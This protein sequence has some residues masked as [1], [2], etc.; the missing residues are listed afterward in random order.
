ME[1]R[2]V[3]GPGDTSPRDEFN[4][5]DLRSINIITGV[6]IVGTELTVDQL[7]VKVSYPY[8]EGSVEIIDLIAPS[9]YDA[10]LSSDGYY[11]A[12]SRVLINPKSLTY[13]TMVRYY[14]NGKL[15]AKMYVKSVDRISKDI[16]KI[17]TMSAIGLME[18][19]KHYGNLYRG[20]KFI[21]VLTEIIGGAVEFTVADDVKNLHIYGWLPYD[22]KRRNLHQ[23]LFPSGVM[24]DKD[25]N[26]DLYFRFISNAESKQVPK[27]RI[28]YGGKVD[29]PAFASAVDVTEHSFFAL[30]TDQVVTVYDNTDGSETAD[31]TF[32]AFRD[33]PLHD[34]E[35]TGTLV[36]EESGVNYAIVTGTGILTGKRYTHST[37]IMRRVA[38]NAGEQRENVATISDAYL[39]NVTNS[40]N[41][42]R[43]VLAYY[44]SRKIVTASIVEDGEKCGDLITGFDPYDEPISGFIASMSSNVSSIVKSECEII[45]DYVP[46]GQG[47]NYS[48]FV[49]LTGSGKWNIPQEVFEKEQ[50]VIQATMIG[51]GEDGQNGENGT[52]NTG[53]FVNVGFAGKGG[54]GGAAG[55]AGKVITMTIDCTGETSFDFSCGTGGADGTSGGNTSFG[56]YSSAS[57]VPSSYGVQNIFTGDIY[58]IPGMAGVDGGDGGPDGSPVSFG[59]Q[60]W[61][62]GEKGADAK[63]NITNPQTGF[64]QF[65]FGYGG[66][67][68]GAAVGSNGSDGGASIAIASDR[69]AAIGGTGGRGANGR[70]G[71]NGVSYGSGGSGGHGGGGGGQGGDAVVSTAGNLDKIKG[72]SGVGGEGGKGGKGGDGVIIIYY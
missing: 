62:I 20:A 9:D 56:P 67:G 26:G 52:G 44:N 16:Y 30:P 15:K 37:R 36:I 42:A 12:T 68:G 49:V 70:D 24:C 14:Q 63:D 34:L 38:D 53:D 27:N 21:D 11:M 29:Y 54:K 2:I 17:N 31:H 41:V 72:R 40:D 39:V 61:R 50:P 43:R 5:S 65:A 33:A 4:T 47:S 19:Q 1:Q 35:T 28:Y 51:A 58:A 45:T 13:G 3:I 55:K 48:K 59:G 57:G 66:Y 18:T 69:G 6:D 64:T 25:E 23:L 71:A 22:T 32:I 60:T 8:S 7:V 46:T 10:T